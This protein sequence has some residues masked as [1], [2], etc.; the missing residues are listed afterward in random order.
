MS[1]VWLPT[2]NQLSFFKIVLFSIFLSFLTMFHLFQGDR[3]CGEQLMQSPE[4]KKNPAV[5]WCHEFSAATSIIAS[6][7]DLD[8]LCSVQGVFQVHFLA[9]DI[10][11][12][13][14][15]F[16][17]VP[18]YLCESLRRWAQGAAFEPH[19]AGAVQ[20][21]T[22]GDWCYSLNLTAGA[23]MFLVIYSTFS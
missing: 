15:I 7:L 16:P 11:L 6:S 3:T 21:Q 18:L 10:Q 22:Q 17:C 9:A 2:H 1:V 5:I 19:S 8:V 4:Q 20:G 12:Q 23:L 14:P 13:P